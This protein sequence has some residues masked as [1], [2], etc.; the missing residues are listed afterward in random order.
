M[1]VMYSSNYIGPSGATSLAAALTGL[2]ALQ[3]VNLR[4]P[5]PHPSPRPRTARPR[6]RMRPA[7]E[8]L[9]V[10]RIARPVPIRTLPAPPN[11]PPPLTMTSPSLPST[12]LQPGVRRRRRRL[13]RRRRAAHGAAEARPLVRSTASGAERG[14]GGRRVRGKRGG[15]EGV[16]RRA[17]WGSSCGAALVG[18]G[19]R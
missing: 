6:A 10:T 1:C 2:V 5:P 14:G 4:C 3:T 11:H 9:H 16:T 7:A 12:Q 18:L 15:S 17:G 19:G 13:R 8:P